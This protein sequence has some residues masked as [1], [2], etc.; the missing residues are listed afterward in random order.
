MKATLP[1]IV[2]KMAN[3]ALLAHAIEVVWLCCYYYVIN[4]LIYNFP[5]TTPTP[6]RCKNLPTIANGWIDTGSDEAGAV[7]NIVCNSGYYLQGDNQIVCPET[8]NWSSF[9]GTC[10]LVT[11]DLASSGTPELKLIGS[12]DG[13]DGEGYILI[14]Q[15]DEKWGTICDDNFGFT[16]AD[17]VCQILGFE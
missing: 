11:P 4:F 8:G 3:G 13:H 14:R 5:V 15:H 17:V 16:E 6:I 10:T 7:R 2:Q 12:K 1:F 9:T